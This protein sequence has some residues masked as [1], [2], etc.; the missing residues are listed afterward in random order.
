MSYGVVGIV[1]RNARL[2]HGKLLVGGLPRQNRLG[3]STC[4]QGATVELVCLI[5]GQT[6]QCEFC[7]NGQRGARLGIA[8]ISDPAAF[9]QLNTLPTWR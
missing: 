1:I 6:T 7:F 3:C 5:G 2:G 9:D 4:C 8:L